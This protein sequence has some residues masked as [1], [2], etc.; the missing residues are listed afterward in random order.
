MWK[1]KIVNKNKKKIDLHKKDIIVLCA[2]WVLNY[3][4]V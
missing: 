1:E 4:Y 3:F 2:K